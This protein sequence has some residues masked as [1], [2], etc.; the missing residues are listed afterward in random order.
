MTW[1][2]I[3]V[4]I[5]GSIH[6]LLAARSV[7]E[8]V[9]NRLGGRVKRYYRFGYNLLACVSF[10]PVLVIAAL[11]PDRRL[12]L[13]PLP[14]S[15]LMI[16]GEILAILALLVGLRQTDLWEFLGVA[17]SS[18]SDG[19]DNA[20]LVTRGLYRYVRHPLYSAG[21]VFIWLLPLMTL[22][23]LAINIGL[24]IYVIAG[25]W[26]EENRLLQEFGQEYALYKASTPMFIP[27]LKGNKTAR[28]TSGK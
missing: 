26:L 10:V 1:L 15:G 14:W 17:Q 25:A 18:G 12:Y 2:I 20:R 3:S 16:L 4:L 11:T 9:W 27:F 22:N 5:W 19:S 21:L 7:K 6:S 13:V 23:V 24:T 8:W 28:G